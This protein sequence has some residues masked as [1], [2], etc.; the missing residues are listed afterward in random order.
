MSNM[1]NDR[2]LLLF[3]LR[4]WAIESDATWG[5][6]SRSWIYSKWC[7]CMR[8][9]AT[10][11]TRAYSGALIQKSPNPIRAIMYEWLA[12]PSSLTFIRIINKMFYNGS[13]VGPRRFALATRLVESQSAIFLRWFFFQNKNKTI[14]KERITV[15]RVIE[16]VP[17]VRGCNASVSIARWEM[18]FEFEFCIFVPC[19]CSSRRTSHL[20]KKHCKLSLSNEIILLAIARHSAI[21]RNTDR[22]MPSVCRFPSMPRPLFGLV[23]TNANCKYFSFPFPECQFGKTLRELGSTW[24]ADLGPPFGVMYCIKCECVPVSFRSIR[25][26]RH[27]AEA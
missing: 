9:R 26:I 25:F 22:P 12:P 4:V 13:Y 24:Y 17:L 3:V 15:Y 23:Q 7:V 6:P 20:I 16:P 1:I 10:A 5:E 18:N 2:I 8:T 19:G 27:L 14:S 21:V 11:A